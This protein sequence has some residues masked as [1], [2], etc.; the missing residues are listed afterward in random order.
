MSELS[1][2]RSNLIKNTS[3]LLIDGNNNVNKWTVLYQIAV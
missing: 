3:A 1:V 2:L